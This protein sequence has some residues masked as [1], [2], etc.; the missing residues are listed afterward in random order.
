MK[1][2]LIIFAIAVSVAFASCEGKN[3]GN[4]TQKEEG[5][6]AAT[7][8]DF[9]VDT[10]RQ[11]EDARTGGSDNDN[12]ATGGVVTDTTGIDTAGTT[13]G[14]TDSAAINTGAGTTAGSG[15]NR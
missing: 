10:E 2:F 15:N 5:G 11:D 8:S 12:Y 7:G 14:Q 9:G 13:G 1:N 6:N 3:H 4:E